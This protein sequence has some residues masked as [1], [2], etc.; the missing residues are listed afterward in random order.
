MNREFS[1][2]ISTDLAASRERLWEHTSDLDQVNR[3]FFPFFKMTYPACGRLLTPKTVKIGEKLFRSWILLFYVLPVE[4]DDITLAKLEPGSG[5]YETSTMLT[6]K[7]WRH[8]R[9]LLNI[10]NG[11]CVVD[12]I[13][14]TPRLYFGG[15]VQKKLFSMLFKY[16]H[17]R[18]K[19]IFG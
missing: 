12:E 16:R 8:K 19:R 10:K 7:K 5:F 14:F 6:Q 4:Y 1:F 15:E 9:T 3:E 13:K 18:L 2:K 11:C 17:W